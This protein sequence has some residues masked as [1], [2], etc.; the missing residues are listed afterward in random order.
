M[1]IKSIYGYRFLSE[2]ELSRI[3]RDL[4]VHVGL[5]Q[6]GKYFGYGGYPEDRLEKELDAF[7]EKAVPYICDAVRRNGGICFH[8]LMEEYGNYEEA[9]SE[10]NSMIENF[11][12]EG[13]WGRYV[14]DLL[15]ISRELYDS[16]NYDIREKILLFD[17][18]VHAMH[19]AGKYLGEYSY[20]EASIFG[21]DIPKIKKE[22]DKILMEKIGLK[23]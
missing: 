2:K 12:H 17:K 22:A 19:V 7:F 6:Y 14:A 21:L 1:E 3:V 20:E 10:L 8:E 13:R 23:I 15:K 9:L 16:K 11:I 4:L 5:Y 18:L